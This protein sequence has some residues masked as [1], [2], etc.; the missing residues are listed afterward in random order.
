M[1]SFNKYFVN[2]NYIEVIR[3]KK[4]Y[5]AQYLSFESYNLVREMELNKDISKQIKLNKDITCCK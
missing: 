2:A 4:K 5:L 1:Y 3:S